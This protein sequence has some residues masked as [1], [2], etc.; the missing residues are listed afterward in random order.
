MSAKFTKIQQQ[1]I[2]EAKASLDSVK[3]KTLEEWVAE[4]EFC[5]TF[6][7]FREE[8][9]GREGLFDSLMK[10]YKREYDNIVDG[11]AYVTASSNTLRALE[12]K[13]AIEV[14]HYGERNRDMIRLV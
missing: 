9:K 1:V 7:E 8:L 6:E 5:D 12:K 2:D 13:G 14:I 4:R 11:I 3:G 10:I